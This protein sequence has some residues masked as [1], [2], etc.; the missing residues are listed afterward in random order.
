MMKRARMRPKAESM[1]GVLFRMLGRNVSS[2]RMGMGEFLDFNNPLKRIMFIR[3]DD[4]FSIR[5]TYNVRGAVTGLGDSVV[6]AI[7]GADF[8]DGLDLI[9]SIRIS[10]TWIPKWETCGYPNFLG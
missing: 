6:F 9:Y 5:S 3:C 10:V 8:L 4:F 2:G 7:M 1:I